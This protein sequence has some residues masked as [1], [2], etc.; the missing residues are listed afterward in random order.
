MPETLT[1]ANGS[2]M[3]VVGLVDFTIEYFD[4]KLNITACVCPDLKGPIFMWETLI[5]LKILHPN[6]PLPYDL[7]TSN[8]GSARD[9][10]NESPV[11]DS[12]KAKHVKK[13]KNVRSKS[14]G[15]DTRFDRWD[16]KNILKDDFKPTFKYDKPIKNRSDLKN[17]IQALADTY[18]DIFQE[19]IA[20]MKGVEADIHYKVPKEQVKPVQVT[21]VGKC[22]HALEAEAEKAMLNLINSGVLVRLGD[23]EPSEWVHR[24]QYLPKKNGKAR[25]ISDMRNLN[26]Y[27]ERKPQPFITTKDI[28]RSINNKSKYFACF[29]AASGF[30]QIPLTKEASMK[31]TTLFPPCGKVP[32]GRYRYTR[33]IQGLNISGDSYN[34]Y[35]DL[36]TNTI[37]DLIKLIDDILLQSDTMQGLLE[38]IEH[39]FHNCR[40]AGITLARDKA[41]MG[42]PVEFCGFLIGSEGVK[43]NDSKLQAIKQSEPPKNIKQLRSFLGLMAQII[44]FQK[45]VATMTTN[46]RM[47]LKKESAYIWTPTHQRDFE[48]L[49]KIAS[50]G[51]LVLKPFDPSLPTEI[52][53]DASR[54]GLGFGL[55]TVNPDG[56]RNLIMAGSRSLTDPET[57]WA[58]CELELLSAVFGV[59]S[60]SF[61]LIGSNK[62]TTVWTDHRPLQSIGK[63][64]LAEIN[65]ARLLRLKEKLNGY[66]LEF[67][68]K[69]GENNYL[70]DFLS[71]N[72]ITPSWEYDSEL[73]IFPSPH[74]KINLASHP[75]VDMIKGHDEEISTRDVKPHFMRMMVTDPMFQEFRDAAKQCPEYQELIKA[76]ESRKTKFQV[77]NDAKIKQYFSFFD[78]LSV[79]SGLI[80]HGND[81]IVVPVKMREKILHLLHKSHA[82]FERMSR[83]GH[84]FYH[85]PKF[86]R[87]MKNLI[88]NC[89]ECQHFRPSQ[90]R[91]PNKRDYN[92]R[93]PMEMLY[94][95]IFTANNKNYL[96]GADRYSS[97][98]FC[99]KLNSMTS[100]AIINVLK[101]WFVHFGYPRILASDGAPNLNSV[102][103]LDYLKE[104]GIQ[105]VTSSP[106]MPRSNSQVEIIVKKVKHLLYKCGSDEEFINSMLHLRNTPLSGCKF[107]PSEI[108]HGRKL[109]STLPVLPSHLQQERVSYADVAKARPQQDDIYYGKGRHLN[110]LPIGTRVLLQDPINKRWTKT[111]VIVGIRDTH[112]SYIVKLDDGGQC[113]R[114]RCYLKPTKLGGQTVEMKP[115][116]QDTLSDK[117]RAEQGKIIVRRS[118]RL[119]EKRHIC[120]IFLKKNS[121]RES[122]RVSFGKTK[123]LTFDKFAPAK[124]IRPNYRISCI[125]LPDSFFSS[126]FSESS[127]TFTTDSTP[128]ERSM[129]E[130]LI[131]ALCILS[132][133]P[134]W[135]GQP[136]SS[137]SASP[138]PSSSATTTTPDFLE[139]FNKARQKHKS[140][141]PTPTPT[142]P[143]TSTPTV[144]TTSTAS[145]VSTTA[146]ATAPIADT[147]TNT[148][149]A[150]TTTATP[151]QTTSPATSSTTPSTRKTVR[152]KSQGFWQ[153]VLN[154]FSGA[155][156]HFSPLDFSHTEKHDAVNSPY[157]YE[158][159]EGLINIREGPDSRLGAF[160]IA[161]LGLIILFSGCA[162]LA[163]LQSIVNCQCL[164][165][166]GSAFFAAIKW[167]WRGLCRITSALIST[168][169]RTCG[170]GYGHWRRGF[171][172]HNATPQQIEM[173]T[174]KDGGHNAS[175]KEF[176]RDSA[177]LS[178]NGL[179]DT[180]ATA[181]ATHHRPTQSNKTVT[182][183]QNLF[184]S[185][186]LPDLASPTTP[187]TSSSSIPSTST[188]REATETLRDES[189][190]ESLTAFGDTSI[191]QQGPTTHTKPPSTTSSPPRSK[192]PTTSSPMPTMLHPSRYW[193]EDTIPT[194]AMTRSS[195]DSQ[196][197][198][199]A[200]LKTP[201]ER[202]T[203]SKA[204]SKQ[205]LLKEANEAIRRRKK[206]IKEANS[207]IE[208]RRMTDEAAAYVATKEAQMASL[209][210]QMLNPFLPDP[211]PYPLQGWK[212]ATTNAADQEDLSQEEKEF[213]ANAPDRLP[214]PVQFRNAPPVMET[215]L[216][217]PPKGNPMPNIPKDL[218]VFKQ[219]FPMKSFPIARPVLPLP[220]PNR[221]PS[222]DRFREIRQIQ[223]AKN[224]LES[225]WS[226][227]PDIPSRAR[228][229]SPTT[230]TTTGMTKATRRSWQEHANS[231]DDE[232][233]IETASSAAAKTKTNPFAYKALE[234]REGNDGDGNGALTTDAFAAQDEQHHSDP[235][236]SLEY[237]HGRWAWEHSE[238]T[239][240]PPGNLVYSGDPPTWRWQK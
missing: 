138:T 186:S 177:I 189:D 105:K 161:V 231:T 56:T 157:T 156:I 45:D 78:D 175:G 12:I 192:S 49:V 87:D 96:C 216:N 14:A 29:D 228:K 133:Q 117:E 166:V 206:T 139:E 66:N 205:E 84:Q 125:S 76:I 239:P 80:I 160:A 38:R 170:R 202:E 213:L 116:N 91:E 227:N 187:T 57:R 150:P 53:V 32:G 135:L 109:R 60:C 108:F 181:T 46:L 94:I 212:E 21:T 124:K 72:P 234:G 217:P 83:M 92:I 25:I 141:M 159:Q 120:S 28:I 193:T 190:N 200:R 100:T 71:R 79:Q 167:I 42:D 208:R 104:C 44:P 222:A 65:N 204:P 7:D 211:I 63:K 11:I 114:N 195:L 118:K 59:L 61:Y 131:V 220:H 37:P 153:D 223:S 39:L 199:T 134:G 115:S 207:A 123:V 149:D 218:R 95:D 24:G 162:I 15:D 93:A 210:P 67:K 82:G 85:W 3:E 26:V 201:H 54:T 147:G 5:D 140:L 180:D 17:A 122:K 172:R 235:P 142:T 36:A 128:D 110:I 224:R 9:G 43:V 31:T 86:G 225:I 52:D 191:T 64:S 143:S 70:P 146:T 197:P 13:A 179:D 41:Q 238:P 148:A 214:P 196:Q 81:K 113:I 75:H 137:S 58:V 50:D 34:N 174:L 77:R 168:C 240:D 40:R 19:K 20:P 188:S 89:K 226:S 99:H 101:G 183:Q 144:A 132:G 33:S 127:D 2:D 136:I 184:Q 169:G 130:I 112:R 229:N 4:T 171:R 182:F 69:P 178:H 163:F 30:F 185:N 158:G 16:L 62:T 6:W 232:S 164:Q 18:T 106:H 209:H 237:R 152:K 198:D 68:W 221:N 47:L 102:E 219:K 176:I 129:K 22:P 74:D 8:R 155:T 88:D 215:K 165:H 23:D 35:T 1:C 73:V 203:P 154:W 145:T 121:S 126:N 98:P 51:N 10:V 107:S 119:A 151:N 194:F 48:E 55:Y 97:Y 103:L 173:K 230:T 27:I 111:G 90:G 236:G 233:V